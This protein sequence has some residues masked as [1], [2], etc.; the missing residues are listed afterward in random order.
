MTEA[1]VT[2][3]QWA[4]WWEKPAVNVGCHAAVKGV[5]HLQNG[6]ITRCQLKGLGYMIHEQYDYSTFCQLLSKYPV[7]IS[8]S[9]LTERL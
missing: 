1:A 8:Y 6:L 5:D 4:A 3:S 9:S 7:T 2:R